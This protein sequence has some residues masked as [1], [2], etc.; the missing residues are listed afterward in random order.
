MEAAHS[1]EVNNS[2]KDE[3]A[4]KFGQDLKNKQHFDFNDFKLSPRHLNEQ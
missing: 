2:L 3:K 4:N 1:G